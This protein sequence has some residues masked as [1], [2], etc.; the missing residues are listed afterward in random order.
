MI[1][2]AQVTS[3]DMKGAISGATTARTADAVAGPTPFKDER[4]VI[5]DFRSGNVENEAFDTA[6]TSLSSKE[7]TKFISLGLH[8]QKT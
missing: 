7:E 2:Q 6:C 8:F 4:V 3:S 1:K 5:A